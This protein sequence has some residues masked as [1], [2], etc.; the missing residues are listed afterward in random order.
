[1]DE[2]CQW[3]SLLWVEIGWFDHPGIDTAI[4]SATEPNHID[5]RLREFYIHCATC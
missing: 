3:V 4:P 1:M 5:L 2:V